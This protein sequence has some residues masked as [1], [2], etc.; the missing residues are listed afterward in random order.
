LERPR[1]YAKPLARRLRRLSFVAELVVPF[2]NLAQGNFD[3][4]G[5]T[6]PWEDVE[7][8]WNQGHPDEKMSAKALERAF[9]RDRSDQQLRKL[10]LD[11]DFRDW[12]RQAERLRHM[13]SSLGM[14]GL[15]PEDVFVRFVSNEGSK[16]PDTRGLPPELASAI[17][18]V[19]S[20]KKWAQISVKLPPAPGSAFGRAVRDSCGLTAGRVAY[21][22]DERFCGGPHCRRCKV[23]AELVKVGFARQEDLVELAAAGAGERHRRR[24]DESAHNWRKLLGLASDRSQRS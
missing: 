2:A 15:R 3:W 14:S 5:R 21:P 12:A 22:R 17:R 23:G 7:A 8:R 24:L 13:L 11:S 1:L 6:I 10:Y 9:R 19:A 20:Y 18:H 4:A 16:E